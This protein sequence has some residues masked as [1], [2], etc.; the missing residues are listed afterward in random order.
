MNS[1]EC[2]RF[3]TFIK[4]GHMWRDSKVRYLSHF[5]IRTL[6]KAI[7]DSGIVVRWY[8]L[9]EFLYALCHR[10]F[11]EVDEGGRVR[12]VHPSPEPQQALESVNKREYLRGGW[13]ASRKMDDE[14]AKKA[15]AKYRPVLQQLVLMQREDD[16]SF[17]ELL[18]APTKQQR[19]A[20]WRQTR[21]QTD[22]PGQG[23][24][25]QY[26]AVKVEDL[27][28]TL[29]QTMKAIR[30]PTYGKEIGFYKGIVSSLEEGIAIISDDIAKGGDQR[31]GADAAQVRE[32]LRATPLSPMSGG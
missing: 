4:T 21:S 5:E 22:A 1:V 27:A 28:R 2:R 26:V 31:A 30:D 19:N 15:L 11:G 20:L 9:P 10:L 3:Q 8:D 14:N 7:H 13:A 18:K 29:V 32:I 12:W 23:E 6:Q 24:F 17:D 16:G 25:E